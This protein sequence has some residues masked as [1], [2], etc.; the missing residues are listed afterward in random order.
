MFF[1][2]RQEDHEAEVA[3]GFAREG[4][5]KG[6]GTN[7]RPF[8]LPVRRLVAW[9][10]NGS[11]GREPRPVRPQSWVRATHRPGVGIRAA[12]V[13]GP[14]GARPAVRCHRS[15]GPGLGIRLRHNYR[16]RPARPCPTMILRS[17]AHPV[18]TG[19]GYAGGGTADA[20][21]GAGA[22][23]PVRSDARRPGGT[24]R[25]G[26]RELP[27]TIATA[28]RLPDRFTSSRLDVLVD[29]LR[30][31]HLLL[32]LD[33]CEHLLGACAAVVAAL[34][35]P[36]PKV[37]VLATSREPLRVPGEAVVTVRPLRLRDAV[38]LFT[39]RA[40]EAKVEIAPESRAT[41][42]SL[43]V[44]L[45]RLPLAIELAAA[46]LASGRPPAAAVAQQ[47]AGLLARLEAGDASLSGTSP[48]GRG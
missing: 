33:T 18:K 24:G 1:M 16:C 46:E 22:A 13:P 30:D 6:D 34:L 19:T 28:L 17:C 9:L 41:V 37:Q 23:F 8:A 45:D 44:Q 26:G 40:A 10:G 47:L 43:C 25:R 2:R 4:G 29:Q 31:R 14:V 11:A 42:A 12:E 39:Q 36:C 27:H 7:F 21:R 5:A 3:G 15:A 20:R 32:V 35:P 38:A 48:G